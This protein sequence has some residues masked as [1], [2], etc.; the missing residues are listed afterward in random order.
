[1]AVLRRACERWRLDMLSLVSVQHLEEVEVVLAAEA[2]VEEEE[3]R[4]GCDSGY[5]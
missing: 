3:E 5:D 1:V 4:I 2:V